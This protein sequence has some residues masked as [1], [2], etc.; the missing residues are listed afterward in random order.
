M[1]R[2]RVSCLGLTVSATTREPRPGETDGTSYYFMSDEEF[3]RHVEAGDF[4]EWAWVHN[5]RYGTLRQEVERVLA[6]RRAR[7]TP[8]PARYAEGALGVFTHL[9]ASP[10]K[11]GMMLVPGAQE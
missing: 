5:H 7:W 4:L 3:D 10:M 8:R 9:A 1:L 6:E 2:E 11:G